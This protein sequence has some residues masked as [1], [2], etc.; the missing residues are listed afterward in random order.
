MLVDDPPLELETADNAEEVAAPEASP[1]KLDAVLFFFL[2]FCGETAPVVVVADAS[3]ALVEE[4][5]GRV[6]AEELVLPM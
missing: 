2:R 5:G 3:E 6:N 4:G 1:V